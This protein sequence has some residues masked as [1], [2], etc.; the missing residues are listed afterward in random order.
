MAPERWRQVEEIYHSALEREES[1]AAFLAQACA[2]DEAMRVEVESLL[3]N[4]GQSERLIE[5]HTL[6]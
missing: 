4:N 3:S 1:R 2:G 6:E 5:K